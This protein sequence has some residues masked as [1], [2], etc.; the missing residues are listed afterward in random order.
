MPQTA[1][2]L[3]MF[4]LFNRSKVGG[5]DFLKS[6]LFNEVS[7]FSAFL[8]DMKS[9]KEYIVIKSPFLTENVLGISRVRFIDSLTVPSEIR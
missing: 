7:F 9:A 4:R 2:G 8:R 3:T 6:E 1:M 5:S